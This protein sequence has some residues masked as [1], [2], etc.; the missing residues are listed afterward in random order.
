MR[1]G[2]AA[3]V[4]VGVELEGEVTEGAG[5]CADVRALL[6]GAEVWLPEYWE[7][8][9][10][11]ISSGRKWGQLMDK[12][13]EG[14]YEKEVVG[15]RSVFTLTGDYLSWQRV[16]QDTVAQKLAS[17]CGSPYIIVLSGRGELERIFNTSRLWKNVDVKNG[18]MKLRI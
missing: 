8:S 7:V 16:Y 1:G 9:I 11:A 15:Y 14:V 17:T 5:A 4:I 6:W 10:T 3:L 18:Y 12:V 2:A 13:T